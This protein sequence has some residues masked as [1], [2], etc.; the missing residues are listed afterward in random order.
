MMAPVVEEGSAARR[1]WGRSA[2]EAVFSAYTPFL[3]ALAAGNLES[4]DF[5]RY[6]AQEAH[7]LRASA[8]A[9]EMAAEYADDDDDKA[10][11]LDLKKGLKLHSSAAEDWGVDPEKE[12]APEPATVK[13][14]NFLL[15]TAQGKFEGGKG[16]GKIVTPFEKTKIAAYAVGAMT[17]C[18][19]LYS[20]LGK[21]M[22][23]LI[24]QYD[25]HFYKKW[26]DNYSSSDFEAAALQTEELLDK[27][28]VA[29]T[30]EELDFIEKLY[31]QAMKLETE[32]FAAQPV[33]KPAV[34]PLTNLH[35]PSKRLFVFSDFDLTCTVVDSSSIL[36][37]IAILTASKADQ[38]ADQGLGD[39]RKT[40]SSMRSSWEALS[41]QYN[42]E[43]EKCIEELLPKEEVKEFD[44]KGLYKGLEDLSNFEKRANLRVVES[45]ML[46]GVNLDDIKRAGERLKFHDGCSEFFQKIVKKK[47]SMSIE[48]HLLSYCWCADL[49][50]SA[51][52]TVGCLNDLIIHSNEF[53]FEE[54]VSTGEIVRRMES[55]IDKV[56][57]FTNIVSEISNEEQ[58]SVYIGDSVGDLLCLLK[59]DVGIVVGESESLRK[60]GKKFGVS[61]VPLYPAL[62]MKQRQLVDK[63]TTVWK[64][65]SGVLYT[66]S[67]W[68]EIRAFLLGA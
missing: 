35:D 10:A 59:A 64:G 6:I 7:F 9:Y 61:F 42:E 55:P 23:S 52:S 33:T 22:S 11:I 30:G 24:P 53:N 5:R 29:L 17:P 47:E 67:S 44:Y 1:F 12:M 28:S 58:M 50:R 19:S 66:A 48:F 4:E 16:A 49:I 40:S 68:T 36:A 3:V 27:L 62:V 20:H 31:R 32:F 51:F 25:N 15:A 41:R 39:V 21:E 18:M 57:A 38:K 14:T 13:Y 2:K 46:R 8:K 56:E 26:I 63:D 60:V 65:L 45:G 37:E 54:S 34:V 43:Y